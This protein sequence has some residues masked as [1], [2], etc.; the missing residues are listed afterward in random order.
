MTYTYLHIKFEKAVSK[1]HTITIATI[2]Y[3]PS[4]PNDLEKEWNVVLLLT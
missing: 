3:C 2:A 1:I 4:N